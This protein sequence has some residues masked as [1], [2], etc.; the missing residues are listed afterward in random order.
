MTEVILVRRLTFCVL[1]IVIVP[2]LL[3]AAASNPEAE[4]FFKQAEDAYKAK[5]LDKALGLLTEALKKEPD[6]AVF[7]FIY[8]RV[9]FEKGDLLGARENFDIVL[10][11]RPT[12]EKNQDYNLKLKNFKKKVKEMQDAFNVEGEKKLSIYQKNQASGEKIKL[13]VTVF[14]AFKLSPKLIY[15]NFDDLKKAVEIYEGALESSFKGGEWQKAP[16]LQLAFLY[17][18]S[19][20]KDKAAEV[21]MRTL[22][23]VADPNE[24]FIITH[25]FD[26]L[27]RSNKE[28]LLDTIESGQFTQK[29][30]AE[31]MGSGTEKLTDDDKKKVEDM[32]TEAR[33]KLEN[34]TTEEERESVLED[35]KASIIEKQKKGELPGSDKLKEKLKKEG[36]TMEDYLKEKGL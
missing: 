1:L 34:A 33:E 32:I 17:E 13:A 6:N 36:K 9:M 8:G 12:S 22:D 15:K 4:G 28:K 21:Y 30:L 7:R 31:M 24:E 3:F 29:D 27:N 11:S 26:Y 25:K 14:Q 2:I 23:Y 16:M 20:K 18:I 10:R 19:N 5:D 35:I